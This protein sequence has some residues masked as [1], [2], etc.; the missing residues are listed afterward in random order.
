MTVRL[1][2]WATMAAGL[3]VGALPQPAGAADDEVHC[4]YWLQPVEVTA[5]AIR[6]V[7]VEIGCYAT[8]A[9][10]IS[11]GSGGAIQLDASASPG[12]VTDADL[13]P[14]GPVTTAGSV[15]IGTEYDLVG[16][17][18]SS[19]T[20]FAS[21][22]CSASTTWEV[23]YVGDAWN[24]LFS[25]GKGFGGCDRNRKF[26]ASQFGGIS[27]LCTPNCSNYGSGLSN[28][29]SSLRWRN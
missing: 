5:D 18:G 26:K 23:D 3:L 2:W 14:A 27:I 6:A 8:Y 17:D 22:T 28:E 4:A 16:F 21:S 29:V 13:E 10:A 7:P 9:E 19:N 24:D 20:Y 15:A 11:A 25:S 12:S 1:R